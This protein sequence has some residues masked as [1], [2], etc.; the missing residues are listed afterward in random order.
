MVKV[1]R[2]IAVVMDFFKHRSLKWN[3]A[4]AFSMLIFFSINAVGY[5]SYN[6]YSEGAEENA[7]NYTYDIV[8]EVSRNTEYYLRYMEDISSLTFFNQA[9]RNYLNQKIDP[10]DISQQRSR[11]LQEVNITEYFNSF[12][13]IRQDIA[14]IY[15]FGN[16]GQVLTNRTDLRLKNYIDIREQAWYRKALQAGGAPVLTSTHVLN[17]LMDEYKWVVSLSR[18]I[19][20][21]DTKKS[22]GVFLINLNFKVLQEICGNIHLGKNNGYVFIVDKDGGLI[23]HPQQQLIYA[24]VKQEDIDLIHQTKD[25]FVTTKIGG[26]EKLYTI[27]T[28]EYT[29]WKF[30]GVT[31]MDTLVPNKDV[32][33][34]FFIAI[35]LIGM[36]FA[37]IL[38]TLI[39]SRISRP[40]KRLENTMKQVQKGNFDVRVEIEGHKEVAQLS[41]TFNLMLRR[42]QD[43]MS[44]LFEEQELKRKSELKALQSQINPHFLYNTLD[45]VIWMAKKGKSDEII[46]LIAS[47]SRLFRLTI[48][49]GEEMITVREELEHVKHYLMIQKIRYKDKLN[50]IIDVDQSILRYRIPRIILQPLVENA[51]YHGIKPSPDGGTVKVRGYVDD[52]YGQKGVLLL[53]VI[54]DGVGISRDKLEHIFEGQSSKLKGGGIGIKNILERIQLYAGKDYGLTFDSE[55][56]KGTRAR[57]YLPLMTMRHQNDSEA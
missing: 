47:L 42:I 29:G 3:M 46:Q 8:N 2:R 32:I 49:K 41:W 21:V 54:D 14:S 37:V 15:I 38:S 26:R 7:R 40:I 9:I 57:I 13:S 50:Y 39:A 52:I 24:K 51:I 44:R 22:L 31:Y 33:R 34:N 5:L 16:Q 55:E 20:D 27:K 17:F 53:E 23:Y 12:L 43:L 56:G 6:K 18:E 48:S 11:A 10:A 36:P 4:F 1:M 30:I 28:S 25:K 19:K 35:S 45:S